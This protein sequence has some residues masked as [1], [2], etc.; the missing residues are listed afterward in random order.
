MKKLPI[1]LTTV[2][3]INLVFSSILF[4]A[5]QK[6]LAHDNGNLCSDE[7]FVN[8]NAMDVNAIQS[9]LNSKGGFLRNYSEGGRSA[10]KIIYDAAH[11]HGD[12]S[13]A[14]NGISV[15]DTI[16]PVA[17]M[18]MLQ[19]EQ[20][21]ITM[22]S[23][24]DGSLNAA[25]GYGCPDGGGCDSRFRGFTKQVENAAWQLRYNYERASGH[26]F[27]NY[28][29]GQTIS[30]DGEKIK[31]GNRCTSSLYRYT[32]HIGG[33]QNFADMFQDWGGNPGSYEA[34]LVTR[35]KTLK[36]SPG[37][38]FYVTV[39]YKN[40]GSAT[41]FNDGSYP[42]RL[43]TQS[44]QD[45]T[46]VFLGS[47]RASMLRSSVKPKSTASFKMKMTA[48]AQPGTYTEVFKPVAEGKTWFNSTPITLT[49]VVKGAGQEN[50]V[51]VEGATTTNTNTTTATTSSASTNPENYKANF[52]RQEYSSYTAKPGER[53]S[54]W[55]AYRNTGSVK[56]LK[57]DQKAVKLGT[58]NPQDSTNPMIGSNR[59]YLKDDVKPDRDAVFKATFT[60]PTTPGTYEI[61]LKPVAE[62]V[63]WFGP[64]TKM[65]VVVK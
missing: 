15:R 17:L 49:I 52:V 6:A 57:T 44:P 30:I 31:L 39:Q 20:S 13:G 41:W 56:W 14:I 61:V 48:P 28:Q 8:V 16:S 65:T 2:L 37:R 11:G 53:F 19:R 4:V 21:L 23:K 7:G 46:S 54:A 47:N 10:A 58:R 43:G 18:A 5:P 22:K 35:N 1:I 50:V 33:N 3:I 42:V 9:F 29:V 55:F 34:Q 59:I 64:E 24:N 51:K 60:A 12:A 27:S 25:M 36:V 26:G 38:V 63:T 62:Y 32:P 40:T 45:R